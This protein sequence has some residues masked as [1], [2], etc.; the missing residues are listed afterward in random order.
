MKFR[1]YSNY[2]IYDGGKIWS[3]KRSKFLK[4]SILPN[5]YQKVTL[6]DNEGNGKSYYIHRIVWESVTG[7]T[8]PKNMQINHR[9]EVKTENF[10]ENLELMTPKQNTNWGSGIER[11]AKARI[12]GK[13]SKQ[14]GAFKDG[15]LVLSFPSTQE[16]GRNG[17]YSSAV[18]ACCRN[19]YS[20]EGNNIYKGFEWRYL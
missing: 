5:G 9:S 17:F 2:E 20:R 11:S 14:V 18:A 16:A 8:I 12:N 7:S 1:D 4:P 10:F 15:K 6:T 3:Y 13:R 19:C